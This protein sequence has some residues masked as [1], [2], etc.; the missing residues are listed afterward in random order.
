[1]SDNYLTKYWLVACRSQELGKK[2]LS[3]S[4]LDTPIVLFRTKRGIHALL[5]RC[6]HRNV[7]LSKGKIRNDV[8]ICPYHGWEF[9][10]QG[11]CVRVPGLCSYSPSEH[12]R[13]TVI[14]VKEQDGFIWAKLPSDSSEE[15]K[16]GKRTDQPF[17][18]P[19][20]RDVQ[21][22][23]FVWKTSVAGNLNNTVENFL[24]AT[25]THYV[26]A[27]L[28][29]TDKHRQTVTAKLAASCDFVEIEYS[30]ES[31]QAGFISK[32]FEPERQTSY[33]RFFMPGIAQIEYRSSK[34]LTLMI[35]AII[36]PT[37]ESF[38]DIYAVVTMK[39]GLIPNALKKMV[40]SPFLKKA[41]KQDI[42]IVELQQ[43]WLERF[44]ASDFHSTQADL[45]RPFVEQLTSGKYYDKPFERS[46][47]LLL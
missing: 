12:T 37:S 36:R 23:S 16:E 9:D 6:P 39:R 13:A 10:G 7:P 18:L 47:Q 24:D 2:P 34:G 28:I 40:L 21:Y 38:Q 45:I 27:G 4:L 25:H 1:M 3:L 11:E 5:D 30:G 19:F 44:G 20:M 42:E 43:A 46:F 29:R 32:V 14:A 31:K 17:A 8:L 22:Y 41:L 15:E 33:G 35:T 26:H